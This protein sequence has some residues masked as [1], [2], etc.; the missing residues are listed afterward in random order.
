MR[1]AR[2][3]RGRAG[4]TRAGLSSPEVSDQAAEGVAALLEVAEL[5]VARARGR[6][7]DDVA[8][9]RFAGSGTDGGR[10][11]T[12]TAIHAAG[13]PERGGKLLGRLADQVDR[14]HVRR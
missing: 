10:Q 9:L 5:V 6:E 2:A 1:R 4:G 13:A 14:A 12:R 11:V 8:R 7:Q 3:S